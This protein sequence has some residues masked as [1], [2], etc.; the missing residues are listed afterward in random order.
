LPPPNDETPP[1]ETPAAV[2][3]E[4]SSVGDAALDAESE[5]ID[6]GAELWRQPVEALQAQAATLETA[7]KDLGAKHSA[8]TETLTAELA[9]VKN[10]LSEALSKISAEP[11]SERNA[12]QSQDQSERPSRKERFV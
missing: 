10:K 3:G 5:H 2:L 9:E 12:D 11:P 1:E 8:A 7:L 4:V 6:E